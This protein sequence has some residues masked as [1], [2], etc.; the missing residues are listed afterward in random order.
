MANV[1]ENIN[2]LTVRLIAAYLASPSATEIAGSEIPTLVRQIKSA[3]AGS[4]EAQGTW[5][6]TAKTTSQTPDIPE[7]A[8]EGGDDLYINIPPR[9]ELED[10]GRAPRLKAAGSVR[11]QVGPPEKK[12]VLDGVT[13]AGLPADM[14][15]GRPPP[16]FARAV[17][18]E[19]STAHPSYIISM[20]NGQKYK[21]LKSHITKSGLTPDEYRARYSLSADYPLV[22]PSY[23]KE[24]SQ[25]AKKLG[26]G[27]KPG[28]GKRQLEAAAL[29][30]ERSA[31]D[32]ST[33]AA[34]EPKRRG[35]PRK[36]AATNA[37]TPAPAKTGIRK[38]AGK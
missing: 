19:E 34:I 13:T 7:A 38:G 26:Y 30:V 3:L 12:K 21:S 9:A 24:R 33:P 25:K 35:R 4:D 17:T 11:K 1:T 8:T 27:R 32:K 14:T 22:A 31:P 36:V 23:A 16:E 6:A 2:E 10:S 29:A 18:V 5:V 37:A 15:A 28:T 20:I